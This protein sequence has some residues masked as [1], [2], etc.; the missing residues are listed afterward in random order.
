[1]FRCDRNIHRYGDLSGCITHAVDGNAGDAEPELAGSWQRQFDGS[2]C[3]GLAS[4]KLPVWNDARRGLP[5]ALVAEEPTVDRW[6]LTRWW[7]YV[8]SLNRWRPDQSA[9]LEYVD[10]DHRRTTVSANKG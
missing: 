1:M 2:L 5:W 7:S 9:A 10:D 4:T 6:T 3:G 8:G